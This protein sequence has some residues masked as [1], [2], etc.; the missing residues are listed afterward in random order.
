MP[1]SVRRQPQSPPR[2][3]Y[4]RQSDWRVRTLRGWSSVGVTV[5]FFKRCSS[6][7]T[8]VGTPSDLRRADELAAAAKTNE[9]IVAELGPVRREIP[10]S[11]HGITSTENGCAQAFS[12]AAMSWTA[13]LAFCRIGGHAIAWPP[14]TR[15]VGDT[16]GV[17]ATRTREVCVT[18]ACRST[19]WPRR[20]K[21]TRTPCGDGGAASP[22][23]PRL[24][25]PCSRRPKRKWVAK[26]PLGPPG[27]Q[28]HT[29]GPIIEAGRVRRSRWERCRPA[30]VTQ[31]HSC[32]T[33]GR[34]S[35]QGWT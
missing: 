30:A 11:E 10:R 1:Q 32:A 35:L 29:S 18:W 17:P 31:W 23:R 20:C 7:S 34:V 13:D 8:T 2:C 4:W 33:P 26:P 21:C 3:G 28:Q 27:R 12:R 6:P 15:L 22:R 16:S 19:K 5:S 14:A 24:V 25:S 9:E